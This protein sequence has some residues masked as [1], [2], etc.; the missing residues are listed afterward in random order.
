MNFFSTNYFACGFTEWQGRLVQPHDK[1]S[2]LHHG[3]LCLLMLRGKKK[4]K[5]TSCYSMVNQPTL[6]MKL[7]WVKVDPLA[8]REVDRQ[9]RNPSFSS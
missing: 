3:V 5:P 8:L 1:L 6:H 7:V 9:I 2:N 4:G